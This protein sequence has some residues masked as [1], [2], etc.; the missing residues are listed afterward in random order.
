MGQNTP[1]AQSY[2]LTVWPLSGEAD[3]KNLGKEGGGGEG[4]PTTL[5][6]SSS[7]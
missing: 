6:V 1:V 4:S 3:N 5:T 7:E 2:S